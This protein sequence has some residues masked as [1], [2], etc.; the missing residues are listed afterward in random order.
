MAESLGSG[1]EVAVNHTGIQW[2]FRSSSDTATAT[3]YSYR[4]LVAWRLSRDRLAAC[5]CFT[6]HGA[7]D[8][9]VTHLNPCE[10]P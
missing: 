4:V 5:E 2:R 7:W 10:I 1:M 6:Y 8:P 3:Y 9:T